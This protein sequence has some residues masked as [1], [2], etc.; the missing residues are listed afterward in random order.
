MFEISEK[1]I[2]HSPICIVFNT[3]GMS[4]PIDYLNVDWKDENVDNYKY[5]H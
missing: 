1:E 5:N 3:I 2:E 4:Y